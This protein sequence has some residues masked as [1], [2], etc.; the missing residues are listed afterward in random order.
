MEITDPTPAAL[1]AQ[2]WRQPYEAALLEYDPSK[3]PGRI[4][5]A[6]EAIHQRLIQRRGGPTWEERDEIEN[7]LR[8]LFVLRQRRA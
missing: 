1:P 7:A 5:I 4:E 8:A 6:L 3:L 2:D